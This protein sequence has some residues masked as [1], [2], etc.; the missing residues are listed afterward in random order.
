MKMRMHERIRKYI[1]ENGMK[2]NFVAEKSGIQQKKFYRLLNGN[3]P[4]DVEEFESICKNGAV[5]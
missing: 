2:L 1:E 4:L 3:T 5:N